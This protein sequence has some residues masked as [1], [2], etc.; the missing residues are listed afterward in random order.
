M[1]QPALELKSSKFANPEYSKWILP[2]FVNEHTRLAPFNRFR[3]HSNPF[4]E[5]D[6]PLNQDIVPETLNTRFRRRARARTVRPVKQILETLN[7]SSDAPI[8]LTVGADELAKVPYKY[9]FF[10]QDVR[11]PYHGTYTRAVSP[12]TARKIA[13]NPSLRALPDTDYDY[14]S[15]AEWQEPEEGDDDLMDEDE[16]SEDEDGEEEMDDFLDD[17]GEVVK[18]QMLVGDMEPKSSGL[19]WEGEDSLPQDGFDLSTY[20]MDVLHDSTMFPID[21]FCTRHWTDIGKPSPS[22]R[23]KT[24][25]S[26]GNVSMQPPRLPLAAV[27]ANSGN[28]LPLANPLNAVCDKAQPENMITQK[29]SKTNGNNGSGKPLKLIPADLLPAFREAVS[30]STLTK[31]GLI[32]VLKNQFPKCSKDGIKNSLES[33]AERRGTKEVEKKW[34]LND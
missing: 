2:F 17:E 4:E 6:L 28:L 15:E 31:T 13:L 18:R 14:D 22:K 32:E 33:I 23:D 10:H 25:Q 26:V 27:D 7:G 30:G 29:K 20:R 5:E 11:P 21:P 3:T 8:D 19:C 16:K 24:Q 1:G 9:L 34:I 12:R